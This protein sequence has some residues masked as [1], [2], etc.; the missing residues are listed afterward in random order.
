MLWACRQPSCLRLPSARREGCG[1]RHRDAGRYHKR[2]DYTHLRADRRRP[3]IAGALRDAIFTRVYFALL[4]TRL[5]LPESVH[6]DIRLAL[7]V[8]YYLAVNGYYFALDG[9]AVGYP[10]L[11]PVLGD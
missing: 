5:Y 11:N 4:H 2:Y 10:G 3:Y 9:R 8:A 7:A 6:E 1:G